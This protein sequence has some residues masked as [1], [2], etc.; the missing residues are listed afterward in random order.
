V[1]FSCL[2]SI[3]LAYVQIYYFK[4]NMI[5]SLKLLPSVLNLLSFMLEQ[6]ATR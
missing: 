5:G 3:T 1:L 4:E 2:I 6:I